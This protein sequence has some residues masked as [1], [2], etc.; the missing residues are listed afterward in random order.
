MLWWKKKKK[1]NTS[2]HVKENKPG[3]EPNKY[4][5]H[6]QKPKKAH[7]SKA[8]IHWKQ[9]SLSNNWWWENR[10]ANEVRSHCSLCTKSFKNVSKTSMYPLSSKTIQR[11]HMYRKNF[12]ERPLISQGRKFKDCHLGLHKIENFLHCQRKN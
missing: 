4:K 5:Q 1:P 2:I 11:R 12:L 7:F 10:I 9:D 8:L 3:T 6:Q